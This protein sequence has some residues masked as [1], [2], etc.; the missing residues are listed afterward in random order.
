M[1]FLWRRGDKDTI[2]HNN[3]GLFIFSIVSMFE[4]VDVW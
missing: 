3:Y 4:K 1:I 2:E